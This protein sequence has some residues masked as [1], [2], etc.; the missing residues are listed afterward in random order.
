MSYL[1]SGFPSWD[2]AAWFRRRRNGNKIAPSAGVVRSSYST[3]YLANNVSTSPHSKRSEGKLDF[4]CSS[5]VLLFL[6]YFPENEWFSKNS[7]RTNR[8]FS[9]FSYAIFNH[10]RGNEHFA[11]F[12]FLVSSM[13][14]SFQALASLA[15]CFK[16]MLSNWQVRWKCYLA[17]P[18]WLCHPVKLHGINIAVFKV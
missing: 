1:I 7:W 8:E 14:R 13:D 4:N 15:S 5:K 6:L 17:A 11:I 16:R 18:S 10:Q 12:K 2:A 9:F 3:Q